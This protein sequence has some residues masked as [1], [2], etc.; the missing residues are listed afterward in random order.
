MVTLPY[1]YMNKEIILGIPKDILVKSSKL[2]IKKPGVFS[3]VG[4]TAGTG[5]GIASAV[6][7]GNSLTSTAAIVVGIAGVGL[8]ISI[9]KISHKISQ[10]LSRL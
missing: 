5:M 4:G 1:I 6:L 9:N 10:N 2:V 7:G 8:G 3:I